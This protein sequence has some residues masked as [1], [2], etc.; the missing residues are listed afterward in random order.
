MNDL[1]VVP[2][3]S[4]PVRGDLARLDLAVYRTVAA[5]PTPTRHEPMRRLSKLADKS[6]LWLPCAGLIGILGGR[7]AGGRQPSPSPP[8]PPTRPW[9]I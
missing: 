7:L 1:V 8:S 6:K 5:V 4:Q 2:R 9:S 3:A